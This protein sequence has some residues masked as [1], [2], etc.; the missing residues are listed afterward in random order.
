MGMSA[1]NAGVTARRAALHAR[2][3]VLD[4]R[5]SLDAAFHAQADWQAMPPQ[6]RAFAQ[7]L[8]R[9][10]LKRHGQCEALLTAWMES[11]LPPGAR[12]VRHILTLGLVQLLWMDVPAH[13]AVH[14][15]V[16]LVKQEGFPRLSGLANAILNRAVREGKAAIASQDEA[17]SNTPPWLWESLCASY[18]E[19]RAREWAM[20]N[21]AEPALDLSIKNP[22][23]ATAWAEKLQGTLLP[24]GTLRI[25]RAGAVTALPGF[26][27][28]AWWV[29]DAASALPA[30]LLDEACGG[31]NGKRVL[32]LCAA[33]GGK[34]AQLAAMGARVS[35]VDISE[36][37]LRTLKENLV[38]LNLNAECTAADVNDWQP[39]FVP[40]A[41]LLD[42]PCSATGTLRRHPDVAWHRTPQ[43]VS[44]LATAQS[45]L[46]ARAAEW[47]AP[48]GVLVYAVCSLL[49]QEGADHATPEGYTEIRTLISLDVAEIQP[50]DGFF[51]KA[52]RRN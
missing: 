28:G 15:A 40:D 22:L 25:T 38:R 5:Q 43:D 44:R 21:L 16:E 6:D 2:V 50:C 42:A 14:T 35:A 32:D 36:N 19:T 17:R 31:V 29:Q 52:M 45:R 18:G 8:L 34:T 1:N 3:Q 39:D 33:P 51:V 12:P 4:R 41:I 37:R 27:E 9:E 13:A 30:R 24:G 7:A 26:E 10:S 20:A 46:L 49:P 48:G 47:L 23:E 11:P